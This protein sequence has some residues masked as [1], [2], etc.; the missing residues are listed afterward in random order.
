M[1]LIQDE[2]SI[3]N[4]G[5]LLAMK[6]VLPLYQRPYRWSIRSGN[7]LFVDLYNAFNEVKI[8]ETLTHP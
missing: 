1:P 8:S 5:D 7:V 6:L 4:I 2:L 3:I